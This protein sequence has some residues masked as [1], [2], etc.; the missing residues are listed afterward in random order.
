[1]PLR[2]ASGTHEWTLTAATNETFR[3]PVFLTLPNDA[4]LG[5]SVM[6]LTFQVT[7]DRPYE[8]DVLCPSPGR[9]GRGQRTLEVLDRKLPNG[10]LRRRSSGTA[11]IPW[12]SWIFAALKVPTVAGNGW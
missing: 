12:K 4:N 11:R 1:M 8:F 5:D 10:Q 7:A 2:L 9:A 6:K 3:L